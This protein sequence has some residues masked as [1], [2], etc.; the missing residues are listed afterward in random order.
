MYLLARGDCEV[1]VIDEKKR[2]Q[3]VR[4]LKPGALFGEISLL[5]NCRRTAKIVSKN[6]CTMARFNLATFKELTQKFPE[7]YHDFK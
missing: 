6:Y 4:T 3:F 5:Y 2:E 7:V 1:R